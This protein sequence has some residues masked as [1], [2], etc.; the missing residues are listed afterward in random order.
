MK[1]FTI[2][3]K[4]TAAVLVLFLAGF[5]ALVGIVVV[6]S[7]SEA[8][9]QA[10][11]YGQ[12]LTLRHSQIVDRTIGE[13]MQ[14]VR[15]KAGTVGSLRTTAGLSRTELD[16]I[17]RTTLESHPSW[18]AAWSVWEPNALDGADARFT[19][20]SGS[21]ATGRYLS[22]WNRGSGQIAVEALADYEKPGAGDYYLLTKK[23]G[24]EKVLDPYLYSVGGKEVLMTSVVAPVVVNGTFLGAIGVDLA[25]STLQ[26][27]LGQIKPYGTG[28][29]MLTT[30]TGVAVAHPDSA[31]IGKPLPDQGLVGEATQAAGSGKPV[32]RLAADG[33]LHSDAVQLAVPVAVSSVDTWAFLVS[34]PTAQVLAGADALQ[35]LIFIVAAVT[36]VVVAVLMVLLSR[37][38]VRPLDS[39]RGRMMEIA[40]GEGDLTQRVDE[41]RG[42]ELGAL[43]AAFNRFASKMATAVG[44]VRDNTERLTDA[45]GGLA[46]TSRQL[47]GTA[48]EASGQ[49]GQ[50]A[51]AAEQVNANVGNVATAVEELG[52]SIRD[53]ARGS[54][55]AAGVAAEAVHRAAETGE[56]VA[57]LG[58][59][60]AEIGNVVKLITAIAEQT[61]LLALN[62]TIEAARAGEQGKGFAV[63]AG[64]VKELAKETAKATEDITAKVAAIQEDTDGVVDAIAEIGRI[65]EKINETQLAIATAVEEQTAVTNDI[66][67]SASAAAEATTQIAENLGTVARSA[68]ATDAGAQSTEAAAGSLAE[69][70]TDLRRLMNQFKID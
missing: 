33:R 25:L 60:S 29:A 38:I 32:Q 11:A 37:S 70:T 3:V 66:G 50:L 40:E 56:R 24:K 67:R 9:R 8:K 27:E 1:R 13:A 23:S 21:D 46:A 22:Y 63:V 26:T 69:I 20:A 31:I 57:R 39:L 47:V 51:A 48:Q 15:E 49:T 58:A 2:K 61:N 17:L 14:A 16:N 44:A 36:L 6:N 52:A 19:N 68:E 35:R 54:G 55:E 62:A 41:S 18:L 43:G 30:A 12:E 59:S 65:I 28:Y 64:E 34:I 7:S 42:D 10:F 53:I 4:L 45:S 5:G